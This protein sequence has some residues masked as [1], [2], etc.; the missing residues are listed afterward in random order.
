[1][2]I[3]DLAF[4]NL[5]KQERSELEQSRAWSKAL[6]VPEAFSAK[7]VAEIVGLNDMDIVVVID[8]KN[9]V[10]GVVAPRSVMRSAP[11]YLRI[12]GGPGGFAG[13]VDEII[14]FKEPGKAGFEWLNYARPELY[15]CNSGNHYVSKLPCPDHPP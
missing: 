6:V 4:Q 11:Q 13:I 3:I 14:K 5:S 2:K 9:A 8:E 1:M 15:W 7:D 10:T 12:G